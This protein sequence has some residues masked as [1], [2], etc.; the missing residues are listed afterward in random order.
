[1]TALEVLEEEAHRRGAR[2]VVSVWNPREDESR[3]YRVLP[4]GVRWETYR[5]F[6]GPTI[7]AAMELLVAALPVAPA[8]SGVQLEAHCDPFPESHPYRRAG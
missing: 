7:E 4:V 6:F 5:W 3:R 2:T 1:M 8:E